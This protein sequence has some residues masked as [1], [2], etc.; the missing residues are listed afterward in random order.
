MRLTWFV[1]FDDPPVGGFGARLTGVNPLYFQY[2][3]FICLLKTFNV[4]IR[5]CWSSNESRCFSVEHRS[6]SYI[7]MMLNTHYS[8]RCAR[9]R[10]C[11]AKYNP[12]SCK[13]TIVRS[14]RCR[15]PG[16]SQVD[17]EAFYCMA[18]PLC[19]ETACDG[20]LHGRCAKCRAGGFV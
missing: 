15:F 3:V 5:Q 7:C 9:G 19:V 1:L 20:L 6:P 4:G 11:L 14:G 12:C 13:S 8:D 10:D 2:A 17:G 18:R 16:W